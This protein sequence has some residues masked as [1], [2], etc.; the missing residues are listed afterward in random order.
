MQKLKSFL[1]FIAHHKYATTIVV[2]VVLIVWLD[3]NSLYNR[4]ILYREQ[5][6]IEEQINAYSAQY[7]RD[8]KLYHELQHDP[9]AAV[10]IARE[11]YYMK[12]DNEDV[13]VFEDEASE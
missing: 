1:H 10:R 3:S 9:N 11:R 2:F 7:E 5:R 4:Y 8:T 6:R 12:N 13:Y